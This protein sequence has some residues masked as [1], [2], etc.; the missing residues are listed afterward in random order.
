[1]FRLT[2]NPDFLAQ[3]VAH[4]PADRGKT[5]RVAFHVAFRRLEQREYQDLMAR[6][7]ESRL[8]AERIEKETG[9]PAVPAFGDRQLLDEVLVGFG[10]DL[11]DEV[12][13][14]LP[15]TPENVDRVLAIYPIQP[16]MVAAFFDN[17]GKAAEKN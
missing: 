1:M 2:T 13:S 8:E 9:R 7:R 12:G 5:T 10:D 17:F 14:P 4:I 3:V 16:R 11:Q 6:L 15:F